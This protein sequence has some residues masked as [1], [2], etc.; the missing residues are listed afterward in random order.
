MIMHEIDGNSTCIEHMKNKTEGGMILAQLCALEQ[1][2]AQGVVP[3]HQVLDNE[4]SM[5]H[6]IEIKQTKH[7]LPDRP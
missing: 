1:M 5:V 2:K 7:D 6:R 3:A 4:I